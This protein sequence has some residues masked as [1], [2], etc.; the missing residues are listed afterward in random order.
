MP[1]LRPLYDQ[2]LINTSH[3]L[4]RVALRGSSNALAEARRHEAEL[5]RR[6]KEVDRKAWGFEGAVMKGQ[7]KPSPE[8][9]TMTAAAEKFI[10]ATADTATQSGEAL[11]DLLHNLRALLKMDIAFVAEFV[12]G[13]K[14][15]REL[16]YSEDS[17][18]S[19][20]PGAAA[21]L[22]TT[23]C[24]RVVDGRS[25]QVMQDARSDPDL[26]SLAAVKTMD[27][28]AYLST[29]VVLRDGTVYGTLCCISHTPR[30][31]LGTRQLDSLRY[32]AGIVAAELE[33]RRG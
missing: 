6:F 20:K 11:R 1:D 8:P 26:A 21:P 13:K 9:I 3:H 15:Y 23:L 32:V 2:E 12:D 16:D 29:P 4:R 25:P 30:S 28:G 24:Q 10:I 7:A 31:A 33:K 22:E 14:I 27:I 19:V 18:V 5:R 17:K